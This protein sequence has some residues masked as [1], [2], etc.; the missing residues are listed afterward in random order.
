MNQEYQKVENEAQKQR[1]FNV[2]LQVLDDLEILAKVPYILTPNYFHKLQK[3]L[4]KDDLECIKYFLVSSCEVRKTTEFGAADDNSAHFMSIIKKNNPLL[5]HIR[6]QQNME[7]TVLHLIEFINTVLGL[8][9]DRLSFTGVEAIEINQ[10]LRAA[11]HRNKF[12]K[13]RIEFFT[14]QQQTLEEELGGVLSQQTAI[15]D[16]CKVEIEAAQKANKKLMEEKMK[17]TLKIMS[18]QTQISEE[19]QEFLVEEFETIKSEYDNLLISHIEIEKKLRAKRSKAEA[20]LHSWI[21][22]YDTDI[23]DKQAEFEKLTE[24]YEEL[25]KIYVK[26]EEDTVEQE[27][28][29]EQ[30]VEEKEAEQEEVHNQC[31]IVFLLNRSARR[32]QRYWRLYHLKVSKRRKK[33]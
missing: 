31:S 27:P 1:F 17:Q 32:I 20:Q 9:Q 3:F 29:Y 4:C 23:G 24:Q 26:L 21:T 14:K 11:Y 19:K 15:L 8:F 25:D 22:K 2:L 6:T 7:P 18:D 28:I 33:A 12:Y 5:E 10:K 13:E 16:G 30:C